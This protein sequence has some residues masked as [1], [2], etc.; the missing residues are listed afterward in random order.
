MGSAENQDNHTNDWVGL[1][2]DA[3]GSGQSSY[4]LFSNPSGIQGDILNTSTRGEDTSPDWV[5]ESA[6]KVTEEGYT[7][8]MRIRSRASASRAVPTCAWE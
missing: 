2:L 6:G 7:A 3:L 4:D 1:S 8:E 5:W